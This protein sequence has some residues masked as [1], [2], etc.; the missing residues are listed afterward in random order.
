MVLNCTNIY[1]TP[2]TT[3]ISVSGVPEP[4]YMIIPFKKGKKKVSKTELY[5]CID[6]QCHGVVNEGMKSILK[7]LGLEPVGGQCHHVRGT[8]EVVRE[9]G[10]YSFIH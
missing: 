8:D 5:L 10:S 1:L 2:T 7:G 6:L 9:R 4:F 3:A